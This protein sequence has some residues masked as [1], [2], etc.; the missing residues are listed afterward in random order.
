M[1]I[2]SSVNL[3]VVAS[4]GGSVFAQLVD[5]TDGLPVNYQVVTDRQC[6][7]EAIATQRSIPHVR[8]EDPDGASFS[9][10]ASAAMG[11]NAADACLL[12]FAR[13]VTAK[14]YE[15]VPTFNPHPS[16]LPKFPGFHAIRS[17]R[18]ARETLLGASLHVVTGAVDNGPL[19]AQ[20]ATAV[21]P[22][23][24]EARWRKISFLQ[25][26]YLSAALVEMLLS[27][28]ASAR[29]QSP[30]AAAGASVP[31]GDGRLAARFH[32]LQEQEN[33]FVLP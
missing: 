1:S 29:L 4:S 32:S 11:A 10:K 15:R 19:V 26:V 2:K 17:A 8:I 14:L 6:G 12:F 18:A 24:P 27:G 16:L 7:I 21:D 20:I 33:E 13:I 25:K 5:M 22:D 9:A 3:A 30:L 31:L 28:P 23:W